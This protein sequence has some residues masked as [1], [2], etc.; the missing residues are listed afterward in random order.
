MNDKRVFGF[1]FL[2]CLFIS[3]VPFSQN[4]KLPLV[5]G[6]TLFL[7]EELIYPSL[8]ARFYRLQNDQLFW[9]GN[10]TGCLLLRETLVKNI[11]SCTRLG[12]E[13]SRY[14][15]RKIS[16]LLTVKFIDSTAADK[17]FTDA[18]IAF[19]K[20]VY[21][22][23]SSSRVSYDEVSK[24]YADTC[25][26]MLLNRLGAVKN[27]SELSGL[28]QS[29]EPSCKEYLLLKEEYIKQLYAKAPVPVK[30]L[31]VS[32]NNFRWV[33][34]FKFDK[35][36]VVNIP[37]ATLKYYQADT[38]ALRMKVVVGKIATKT[39]R[40]AAYCDKVILYPYWNVPASIAL[41]ELLPKV[42]R[43]PA[44]LDAMNMQVVNSAGK[45]VSA[46]AINWHIYSRNN[47][48]YRFRQ[49]TGC[50]NSLGVIKFNVTDPYSVYMH[51]TNNKTA[52]LS[53]YRFY[54]HGCIRLEKPIE[55]G[56]LLLDNKLDTA[57]LQSC[58]KEQLPVEILLTKPVP[59]FVI[60]VP[61]DLDAADR[62][63]YYKDVYGL[64]K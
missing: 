18:A 9:F 28:F 8:V 32:L 29:L 45:V 14:H 53:G 20:D 40:F 52:F 39:P 49:S 22:G 4:S 36:I 38:I 51:D 64:L 17:V 25:N 43:N 35:Y 47:F 11:D 21:E 26:E 44:L 33:S 34:H 42:K 55:L 54:S 23:K 48:P 27:G 46:S 10:D 6:G 13:P 58:Y 2:I 41:N 60:Y 57:F 24:K 19:C 7:D 61:A 12:L 3:T 16:L 37:S 1:T 56:N 50:D 30:Q 62:I 59:V 5:S 31:A 63:K 15:Q